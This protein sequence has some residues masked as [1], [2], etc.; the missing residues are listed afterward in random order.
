MQHHLSPSS[1]SI[2]SP[3][4]HLNSHTFSSTQAETLNAAPF[5]LTRT[6]SPPAYSTS[7][8]M[9]GHPERIMV[10][11]S[12]ST[13]ICRRYLWPDKSQDDE[14]L[15]LS[16]PVIT[17]WCLQWISSGRV[18]MECCTN[19]LLSPLLILMTPT[20]WSLLESCA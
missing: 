16:Y 18:G 10:P 11:A 6:F 20:A 13:G 14:S 8:T 2:P 7:V 15:R 12:P 1:Q 5:S 17:S 4:K 19:N 9:S 3:L